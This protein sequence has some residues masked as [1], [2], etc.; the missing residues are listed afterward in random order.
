MAKE[1]LPLPLLDE[2]ANKTVPRRKLLLYRRMALPLRLICG[3]V[4][5]VISLLLKHPLERQAHLVVYQMVLQDLALRA[6]LKD[7]DIEFPVL[8]ARYQV[9]V[10]ATCLFKDFL[11]EK[12]KRVYASTVVEGSFEIA[13]LDAYP[14]SSAD[15]GN[16]VGGDSIVARS[17]GKHFLNCLARHYHIGVKYHDPRCNGG[18]PAEIPLGVALWPLVQDLRAKR[19]GNPLCVVC[20]AVVDYDHFDIAAK[21][22]ERAN[23]VRDVRGFVPRRYDDGKRHCAGAA[24]AGAGAGAESKRVGFFAMNSHAKALYASAPLERGSRN[25]TGVPIDGA[26]ETRTLRGI[27]VS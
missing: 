1:A 3:K 18:A 14:F 20:R 2:H 6:F 25:T 8:R 13:R 22:V 21:A 11:R 15:L 7:A 5:G 16:P 9:L 19:C 4:L 24:G 17:A 26:S 12:T 27:R 23:A 10:I